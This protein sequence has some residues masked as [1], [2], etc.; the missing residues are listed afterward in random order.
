MLLNVAQRLLK[1]LENLPQNAPSMLIP[2]C[3]NS[4]SAH[5][6]YVH[7]ILGKLHYS[8]TQRLVLLDRTYDMP[9]LQKQKPA[10]ALSAIL[11]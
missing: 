3:K 6:P 7:I 11:K 10:R 9:V 4:S 8:E 2:R 5:L 1:E